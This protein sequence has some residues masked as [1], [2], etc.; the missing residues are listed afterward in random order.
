M[1]YNVPAF[2]EAVVRFLKDSSMAQLAGQRGR[3]Y[4][5][6]ERS[7]SKLADEIDARYSKLIATNKRRL[8]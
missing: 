7:Y 5:V 1:P 6:R 3:E 4:V 2:A 8:K